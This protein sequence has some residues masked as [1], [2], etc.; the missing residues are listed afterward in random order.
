MKSGI[1]K[2]RSGGRPFQVVES[3]RSGRQRR[4][5][6]HNR[7][8]SDASSQRKFSGPS[9]AGGHR[10][11]MTLSVLLELT[12]TENFMACGVCFPHIPPL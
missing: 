12:G 11:A 7:L 1:G 5:K 9:R 6:R 4:V 3:S 10:S 2:Q 8:L